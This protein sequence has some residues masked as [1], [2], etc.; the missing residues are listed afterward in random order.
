M[1]TCRAPF[2]GHGLFDVYRQ[3]TLSRSGINTPQSGGALL[4]TITESSA[5]LLSCIHAGGIVTGIEPLDHRDRVR[6]PR[7]CISG[8]VGGGGRLSST[9]GLLRRATHVPQSLPALTGPRPRPSTSQHPAATKHMC[10]IT[11]Q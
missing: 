1:F 6:R 3:G 5:H 9:P 2:D 7:Y 8:R 4:E 11:S 10:G